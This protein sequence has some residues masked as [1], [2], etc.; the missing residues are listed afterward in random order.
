MSV[1]KFIRRNI[2]RWHRVTSLVVAIPVLLWT[3][4]GFLHPVMNSFKPEVNNQYLP[5]AVIDT[6][7]VKRSLKEV[8]ELHQIP[9]IKTF[10]IVDVYGAPYYQIIHEGR[11]T[12][13][14]ISCYNGQFLLNGDQQYASYLAQ[15]FLTDPAG[16]KEKEDHHGIAADLSALV[17]RPMSMSSHKKYN[18]SDVELITAFNTEYKKSNVLLPVYRV[19]FDREDGIRLYIETSTG[20]LAAAVDYRKAWFTRFFSLTHTWSFLDG[21]GA[22]KTV[23]LFGFSLLC[24][25]TSLFGFYIYNLTKSKTASSAGRRT[26]RIAGNIFVLTTL[27]YSFS[28]AW[29]SMHKLNKNDKTSTESYSLFSANELDLPI[30]ELASK[31]GKGEK[32]TDVSIIPMKG[33]HYWQLGI[34]KGKQKQKRYFEC[35]RL[36][37]LK[38][39]DEEYARHLAALF[40]GKAVEEVQSARLLT[41][42]N[43]H[44]SM[45]NKR[46]P[47]FEVRF[48]NSERYYVETATGKLALLSRPVD[49]AERFSFSNL[50]MHHYWEMWLG[51]KKGKPVKNLVLISSTL[52][53]LMLALTGIQLYR[54]KQLKKARM[55]ANA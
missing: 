54:Q 13:S 3:V 34:S 20:K 26:H 38:N 9:R 31:L 24:F 16:T 12:L 36:V 39:G 25:L 8:L 30:K 21:L 40:S 35:N 37:E 33:V 4:S 50:H 44:Y 29:H 18:I 14:Y 15:R 1:K 41:S 46:L 7:K 55:M 28:G 17:R 48:A 42:F 49:R 51:K 43:H 6:A 27:L 45:M 5:S 53:L 32:L 19:Q 47:V 52:G 23:L 22:G 10:H 2:Y 11:D